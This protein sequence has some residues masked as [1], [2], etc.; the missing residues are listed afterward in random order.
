MIRYMGGLGQSS[1][2]SGPSYHASGLPLNLRLIEAEVALRLFDTR[3]VEIRTLVDSRSA[4]APS[5]HR[6][7]RIEADR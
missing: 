4:T 7:N 6:F 1:D 5:G 3:G 2:P